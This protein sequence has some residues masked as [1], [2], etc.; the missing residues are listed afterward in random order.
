MQRLLRDST[1]TEGMAAYDTGLDVDLDALTAHEWL[2][3]HSE[4]RVSLYT[5]PR[6]RIRMLGL[7]PLTNEQYSDNVFEK[8]L[9]KFG[10]ERLKEYFYERPNMDSVYTY[11][12]LWR[13]DI[14]TGDVQQR[15][16]R[17]DAITVSADDVCER[18][19]DVIA[20]DATGTVTHIGEV[21]TGSEN[22]AAP[23][24]NWDKL[25]VFATGGAT[26]HWLCPSGNH[27]ADTLKKLH[28][29]GRIDTGSRPPTTDNTASVAGR[30]PRS[31]GSRPPTTDN[32]TPQTCPDY[33]ENHDPDNIGIDQLHALRSS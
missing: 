22:D 5:V 28:A 26:A 12:D 11:Y 9:H 30:A 24:R 13:L 33:L 10:V 23:V 17:H 6:K 2:E 31:S 3:R 1:I 15:I 18:R 19:A 8:S 32:T 4:P 20:F 21:Q 29:N 25:A 7:E 16:A 27:M 14:D